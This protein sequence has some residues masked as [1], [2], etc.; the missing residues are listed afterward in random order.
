ME[1]E[2]PPEKL[3]LK[4][5]EVFSL[6]EEAVSLIAKCEST[7]KDHYIGQVALSATPLHK[8]LEVYNT[9]NLFKTYVDELVDFL[10]KPENKSLQKIEI[11]SAELQIMSALLL[12][13]DQIKLEL[14]A[15]NIVLRSH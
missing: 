3:F 7:L 13:L 5:E 4:A 11:S 15:S 10:D 8:V 6:Q 1:P 9:C 14:Q 2:S 12:G